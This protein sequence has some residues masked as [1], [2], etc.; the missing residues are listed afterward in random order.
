MKRLRVYADT[1]VFGGCFDDEFE[2]ESRAF[3]REVAEGRFVL[4]VSDAIVR[5]LDE[6]PEDVQRVLSDLPAEHIEHVP[7]SAEICQ[8]REAYLQAGIVGPASRKDAEH[9]AAATVAEVDVVVSW[10]FRHIV[11]LDKIRHYEAANL[12]LGYKP[13]RIHSPKEIIHP[14]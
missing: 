1:S 9:I 10:N 8:L 3:F 5:E 7:D 12:V 6:A 2:E 13:L 4:V 11:H 14:S